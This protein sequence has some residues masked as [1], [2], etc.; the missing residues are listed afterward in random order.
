MEIS[1][2]ILK[3]ADVLLAA[4]LMGAAMLLVYDVFRIFRR[5]VK[6]GLI[7]V[8]AEDILFWTISAV[9][10]FAMLYKENSGYIR[11][12]IIG[13]VMAGMLC[14]NLLLS[15]VVVK[16]TVAVLR[17]V[18]FVLG[19][20]FVWLGRLLKKPI[21]T[22]GN[23]GKK[24]GRFVKKRLKKLWKTVRISLCKR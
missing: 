16:F 18:L 7:W 24:V 10:I 20:P 17:K 2:E 22:V 13:G 15:R 14:Y 11:G 12:F 9:A 5:L 8:G 19:R 3:E 4:V 1:A 21:R 6:H 23:V